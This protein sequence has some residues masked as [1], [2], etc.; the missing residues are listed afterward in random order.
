MNLK[1]KLR[2]NFFLIFLLAVFSAFLSYP[3]AVSKIS[4]VYNFFDKLKINLGLDLQGGIHLE[5]KA[6]VS[7]IEKGKV[8]E[9]M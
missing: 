4:P 9:A 5:Y 1:N 7:Q 6:D 3:K 8:G 2:T